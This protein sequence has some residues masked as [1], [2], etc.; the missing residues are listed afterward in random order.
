MFAEVSIWNG[1]N[2]S[3]GVGRG[4]SVAGMRVDVE[5]AQAATKALATTVINKAAFIL[6]WNGMNRLEL[7]GTAASDASAI[8][9]LTR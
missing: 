7:F 4:I 6:L 2:T 1:G 8:C 9:Y 3:G 5:G